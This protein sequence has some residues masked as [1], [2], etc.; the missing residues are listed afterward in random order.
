MNPILIGASATLILAVALLLWQQASLLRS[1]PGA[2]RANLNRGLSGTG[3]KRTVEVGGSAGRLIAFP[4]VVAHLDRLLGM[5]GRPAHWPLGKVLDAKVLGIV[6]GLAT[7]LLLFQNLV[8]PRA[9]LGLLAPPVVGFFLPDLLLYNA[10]QKR[11]EAIT[12]ALPDTLDQLSIAVEAGLGFDSAMLHVARNG[13]GP[14]SEEL[15]RTLQDIQVG[16]SRRDA[17]TA[18]GDRVGVRPLRRFLRAVV[19][20]EEYGIALADV[21]FTQAKEMR[22]ERRQNAE[23]KA[24]KIPVKVTFPL[25][26]F[27]LPVIFLV[28]LGPAVISVIEQFGG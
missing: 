4:R 22:I 18:L 25:A 2:I 17:Y 12:L 9:L 5:A 16:Q 19:Q 11:R 13:R 10:A 3:P 14:L 21:L 27:I 7:G 28:I 8:G 20:A 24:M 6:L 1:R 15:V 23:T 26:L